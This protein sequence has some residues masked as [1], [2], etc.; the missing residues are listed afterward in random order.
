MTKKHYEAIAKIL[1]TWAARTDPN[2]MAYKD[3]A[4]TLADYMARENPRFNPDKFLEVAGVLNRE[5][6]SSI[7]S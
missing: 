4:E 1:I 7:V 6:V 3:L 5:V 2:W